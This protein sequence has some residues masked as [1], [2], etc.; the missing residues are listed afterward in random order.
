MKR[1]IVAVVT[2]AFVIGGAAAFASASGGPE[3]NSAKATIQLAAAKFVPARC[4]GED[5]IPYITYRG[6]WKGGETDGMP[7]STDYNLSGSLTVKDGVW[8]INLKTDRGVLRGVAQLGGQPA[9][10]GPSSVTYAGLLTLITQG[11]PSGSAAPV[12]ARGWINAATHTDGKADGGSLLANVEFVI[13]PGFA[14]NGE[15]GSSMGF[16]DY[17]VADNNLVC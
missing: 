7:G 14:A 2:S 11:F 3:I 8:T 4:A 5:G 12:K 13:L 1:L 16:P 15:F 10:G 9:A 17:S 6:S